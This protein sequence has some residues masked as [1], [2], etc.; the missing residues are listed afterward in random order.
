MCKIGFTSINITSVIPSDVMY[1]MFYVFNLFTEKI[2]FSELVMCISSN[3]PY[4]KC[5]KKIRFF[6]RK[7]KVFNSERIITIRS[8]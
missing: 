4:T 2:A 8:Q 7:F 1:F 6:E 5:S 3:L